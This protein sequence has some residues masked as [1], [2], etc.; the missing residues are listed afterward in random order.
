M[1]ARKSGF[2]TRWRFLKT[3]TNIHGRSRGN[4]LLDLLYVI[5]F[6]FFVFGWDCALFSL[7]IVARQHNNQCCMFVTIRMIIATADLIV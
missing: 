7:T 3:H 2:A 1:Q 4:F 5:L 6:C